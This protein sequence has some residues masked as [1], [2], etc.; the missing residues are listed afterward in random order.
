MKFINYK[1][2][3][4]EIISFAREIALFFSFFIV[5]SPFDI[6]GKN[7]PVFIDYC[8]FRRNEQEN[9]I[10]VYY[11]FIDN[12]LQFYNRGGKYSTE[13]NLELRFFAKDSLLDT[14]EWSVYHERQTLDTSKDQQNLLVGQKN[15]SIKS[16]VPTKFEF[17][18]FD[19][20]DSSFRFRKTFD[21]ENPDFSK[22]RCTISDIQI[23][24]FIERS[25]TA[26]F[27]WQQ[28]FLKGK[29]YVIPNPTLEV[30]GSGDVG[31]PLYTY[32]E[33]YLSQDLIGKEI[34]IEYRI[35]NTLQEEVFYSFRKVKVSSTAQFDINGFALDALHSASY[36]F[37]TRIVG[38]NGELLA[39][40][41]KKKFY[42]FNSALPP[43]PIKKYTESELFEKSVFSSMNDSTLTVEFEKAKYIAN[44]YEKELFKS[45]TTTE[46]KRRFLFQFWRRRNPDTT[47]IY[48]KAYDDF[49][50]K[51]NYANRF[52]SVGGNLEGWKTDRG[53]VLIQYGEPT[54]REYHPREP[55]KRS[56]EIWFYSELQ[57]GAFFYF[58]DLFGNGNY[59]LVHST[60]INE[61]Y[62]E[63]WYSDFVTGTNTERIQKMFLIR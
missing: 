35:F 32:F 25:D 2:R 5:F 13:L 41:R 49:Q 29:F 43:E 50:Q 58:V 26:S 10:E 15:F 33:Y 59:V 20:V 7:L 38:S 45:L 42:L 40:S 14:Y 9:L 62:N 4:I 3:R 30:I 61:I 63:N 55:N 34:K 47:L 51:I 52:F 36:V 21:V 16:G 37:E 27:L 53:R 11:G 57:G 24:Q 54:T 39:Q 56:Y 17:Y 19:A 48:N 28:E 12:Q 31:L 18:C 1:R 44:D 6:L 22:S 46:A 23:A 60:A 8:V